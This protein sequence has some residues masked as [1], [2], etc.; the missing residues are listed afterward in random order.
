MT[1]E[2]KGSEMWRWL[3]PYEIPEGVW[4]GCGIKWVN[5]ASKSAGSTIGSCS[6]RWAS[7]AHLE[8]HHLAPAQFAR[9]LC[10]AIPALRSVLFENENPADPGL[11]GR[12]KSLVVT[13]F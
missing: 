3:A 10:F 9:H 12:L 6:P 7:E 4:Q 2:R 1:S 5:T 13:L 11:V 8:R